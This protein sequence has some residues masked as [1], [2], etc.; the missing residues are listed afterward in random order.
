MSSTTL[1]RSIILTFNILCSNL[2]VRLYASKTFSSLTLNIELV[3]NF[4]SASKIIR[5]LT[6]LLGMESQLAISSLRDL[7]L[8][9]TPQLRSIQV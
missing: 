6:L 1:T 9:F 5:H 8:T 2:Q 3:A 7:V 4:L